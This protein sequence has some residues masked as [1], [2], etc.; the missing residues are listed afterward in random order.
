MI[1]ANVKY[2]I[3][4]TQALGYNNNKIKGLFDLYPDISEF[5][6]GGEREWKFCG[7]LSINDIE[8]LKK[9][10]IEVSDRILSDC[11]RLG[12]SVLCIDDENYP[13]CLLNIYA[14]PAVLYING[15]F[16]EVD[17]ILTIGIVGTRTASDYGLRN[18][19][20]I[21]YSLAKFGVCIVSGGAL[22]VDCAS[23]RGT[24]AADGMTICVLGC[25]INYNYLRENEGMRKAIT[26]RGAVISEYPPGTP[27]KSFHFPQRNRIIAALSKGVLIIESGAKSGSLITANLALDMGKELFALLGNS[28]PKNEGSNQRIKEGTA[29]PITDFMDILVTFK[30]QYTLK[31]ENPV[32]DVSLEDVDKIPSKGKSAVKSGAGILR[33]AACEKPCVKKNAP[34]KPEKS[35]NS[36]YN[37]SLNL[38]GDAKRVYDYLTVQPVHIDKISDDLGIPVFRVLS[39]LTQLEIEDLVKALHGRRFSLR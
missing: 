37:I 3:W 5:Y 14:P 22:G 11:A 27:P 4:I 26:N 16:P 33:K 6:N 20:K 2:W 9:T 25:G 8:N 18:S 32:G 17:D 12:Y 38:T 7:R 39:A 23:H 30:N 15:K 34:Q 36:E 13:E 1:S 28:S 21:G 29:I 35:E 10:P 31:I 24:L 19:Y